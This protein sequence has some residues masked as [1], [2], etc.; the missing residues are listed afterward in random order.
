[1]TEQQREL[2]EAWGIGRLGELAALPEKELVSRMGQEGRR[3]WLLARGAW[4]HL[5]EPVEAPFLLE[6]KLELEDAVEQME[7]L[8]FCLSPMLEEVIAAARDRALAI[9]SLTITAGLEGGAVYVRVLRPALPTCDRALMLKLVQLDMTA[10]PP[11]AGVR[12]L[13]VTAEAGPASKVQLGLFAPQLP[14]PGRLQVTLA[15]I[16]AIVGEKRVGWAAIEDS[17]REDDCTVQAFQ[18]KDG[19]KVQEAAAGCTAVRR[20][21]PPAMI[22]PRLSGRKPQWFFYAG[23]PYTVERQFGR[24][25]GAGRGGRARSGR[26]STGMWSRTARRKRCCC[27]C[28]RTT[29]C[30]ATG[31]WRRCMTDYVELHAASAFSFLEGGS[32]PEALVERAAELGMDAMALMD[33]N[34]L[35]GA[36]RFHAMAAKKGV[37]AHVGAEIV[38][39]DAARLPVLCTSQVGYKNLCQMITRFKM[40]EVTKA[41]G[42]ARTEDLEEFSAGMVCLTGGADGVLATALAAGGEAK[43]R[44]E[45][46]QLARIYGRGNVYVE[47]QRHGQREEEHRNCA[48]LALAESLQLPVLATNGVRYATQPEREILDLFTCIRNGK[49]LDRAGRLLAMNSQRYLRSAARMAELFRD[50]PE[51]I[52]NTRL[53]SSRLEFDLKDLGY[54][55]PE[56]DVPYGENMESFL[57]KRVAEGVAKRY[58]TTLKASLREA[59]QKQA[60]RELK[61]IVELG[62]EGYFL[63]VW[64]IVRYCND[65]DILVQGRGSAANSVVCYVL[66]IT[67]VDPIGMELLLSVF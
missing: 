29:G 24:G 20:L 12:A 56:Y 50:I 9:A 54:K 67:A 16:A 13:E 7:S 41:E 36:P 34:G 18:V 66:G 61:L 4:T 1:M 33:R 21:R 51:A 52:G 39:R 35:Y 26:W 8:L 15:R 40:R 27:A 65:N 60:E 62:F 6:Q 23:K 46:E 14:E 45:L 43:A 42:A 30:A 59:A 44:A 63:I 58:G 48:A 3:L 17:H 19:A 57:R 49:E 53:L 32:L 28:W 5:F 22:A 55:F 10:H 11:G 2:L 37:K 25:S 47:L 64:D 31:A 38:L